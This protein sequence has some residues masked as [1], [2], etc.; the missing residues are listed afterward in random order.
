MEIH[1]QLDIVSEQATAETQELQVQN[2]QTG[3]TSR[4]GRNHV[5]GT[6][7]HHE[8][9]VVLTAMLDGPQAGIGV[10]DLPV[11]ARIFRNFV[12]PRVALPLN[13]VRSVGDRLLHHLH[14]VGLG[15]VN[16]L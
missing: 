10:V 5:V 11:P 13:Q 1:G 15:P 3:S 6:V 9:P 16:V 12:Q 8:L 14:H 2:L 7:A 4:V